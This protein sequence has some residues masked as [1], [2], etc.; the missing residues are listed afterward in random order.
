[1]PKR[2]PSDEQLTVITTH[3][4]ADFDAIASVLAAQKLYLNSLVILPSA[5]EKSMRD[6]FINSIGYLLNMTDLD[7][8]DLATI[9]RL[10]IVDTSQKSRIGKIAAILDNPK[11]RIHIYDHHPISTDDIK[12]HYEVRQLTGATV[13][14]LCEIL[15]EKQIAITPDEATILGLGIY[16]DTGSFTFP[17]TTS[18]DFAAAAFLLSKG[19]NLNTISNLT[20]K[21]INAREIQLLNEMIN[22]ATHY[23]INGVDVVLTKITT[24]HYVSDFSFL[25]QKMAKIENLEALFVLAQMENKIYVVARSQIPEVD[26]G[27]ILK[28]MGGGGH[29]NA[30]AS[31]IREKTLAQTEQEL[32]ALVNQRVKSTRT[33]QNLMSSPAITVDAGVTIEKA[34]DLLTRYNVNALLVTQNS[35]TPGGYAKICGFISRQV[36]EKAIFHKL[37]QVP[38]SE[39]MTTEMAR[40]A[41][42][43]ELAEIQDKIIENKQRILPVVDKDSLLGVV[44]RTDLLNILASQSRQGLRHQ[45]QPIRKAVH[46][47]TKNLNNFMQER[48]SPKILDRLKSLGQVAGNIGCNAYVV[49]GFVRDL[50]L[51]RKNEDID[52]VIE[53]DG[54]AFAKAYAKIAGARIHSHQKFG[55]AVII[56]PDNFKIDVATARMEYYTSPAALPTVEKSSIKLDLYRRD[57]TVNTL[58]IKLNSEHFGTLIDFYGAYKDLKAKAIR[59]LHN[60]S[61]VED[62]TRVFRAIRFEQRFGFSI[63]KLTSSLIK[64]AV[65]MGFFNRLSGRRMF[66]ELRQIVEEEYP[67]RAIVR[68]NDYDL[69]EVIHPAITLT[70]ELVPAINSVKKVLSW[71]DLLFLEESYM[72]WMVYFLVIMAQHDKSTSLAICRRLEFAP[73]QV[74]I[75]CKERFEAYKSMLWIERN[76]SISNSMLY[77]KLSAFKTEL[78]LYMMSAT[79]RENVKKLISHYFTKLRYITISVSGTDLKRMGFIP[80]P[81][82]RELFGAVLDAKLNG[83]VK[84]H[85]DELD[86]IKKYRR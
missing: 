59:V 4:N 35:D 49:G 53:G 10:V 17:S 84:T 74:D 31:A 29:A 5:Q 38:V 34:N 46:T 81:I 64:N 6:F 77:K 8:I 71:F 78:I 3:I 56:F 57:F 70:R 76:A 7:K 45:R 52:I 32:L 63:G 61:F 33:A 14:I 15:K 85:A 58:I 69:L 39:Y 11:L 20:A 1:L 40:V 60:L 42:N 19:A 80:G 79:N 51:Y 43:A 83:H 50:L 86:F 67:A 18:R 23:N 24:D 36:I 72:K 44:T 25:V 68:L 54:I 47:S 75:F 66:S 21:E 65:K 2:Y 16:E 37:K 13:T 9:E 28:A 27:A 55:T 12:G 62:P 22:A 26:V 41:P 73:R 82:Y 48:L 30:A